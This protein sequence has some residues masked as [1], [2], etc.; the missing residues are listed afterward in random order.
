MPNYAC[1]GFWLRGYSEANMLEDFRKFLELFPCSAA[2]PGLHSLTIR[3]VDATQAAVIQRDYR[4]EPMQPDEW[5]E[6]A[7]EFLHDDG[8]YETSAFWDLWTLSGAAETWQ[9]RLEAHPVELLCHGTAY[10]D[11]VYQELGHFHIVAGPEHLFVG[12]A[13]MFPPDGD[14]S[15][16]R[17]L[18]GEP[19]N[20]TQGRPS[21][22]ALGEETRFASYMSDEACRREYLTK[23]QENIR[24]LLGWARKVER[25]LPVERMR[26][27]SEGEEDF[28]ER[29]ES[30]LAATV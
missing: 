5:L 29:I 1:A 17:S 25:S 8:S 4:L 9:W 24:R 10:D 23:T 2:R 7:Q 15:S 14:A 30:I 16:A 22:Q 19:L 3:A 12:R 18:P 28:R 26:L 13:G 20:F 21:G 11:E 27:W 6:V